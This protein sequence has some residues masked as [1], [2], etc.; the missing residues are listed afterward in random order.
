MKEKYGKIEIAKKSLYEALSREL[1]AKLK[2]DGPFER[3]DRGIIKPLPE[4]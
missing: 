3:G 2:V 4:F 1:M